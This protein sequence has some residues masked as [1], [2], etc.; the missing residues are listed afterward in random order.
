VIINNCYRFLPLLFFFEGRNHEAILEIIPFFLAGVPYGFVFE[1]GTKPAVLGLILIFT[2]GVTLCTDV[3]ACS[4]KRKEPFS[5]CSLYFF[6]MAFS[7]SAAPGV[8]F[9]DAANCELRLLGLTA[10]LGFDATFL[11]GTFVATTFFATA[12]FSG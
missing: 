11:A 12:F 5:I 9:F 3:V 4:R 1:G 2:S 8:N 6:A 7:S 10:F